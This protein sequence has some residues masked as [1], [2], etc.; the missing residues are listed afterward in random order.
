MTQFFAA[1]REPAWRTMGVITLIGGF[2]AGSGNHEGNAPSYAAT[3]AD[4]RA[5][6]RQFLGSGDTPVH[7]MRAVSNATFKLANSDPKRFALFFHAFLRAVRR[8]EN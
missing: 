4:G 7:E 5:A 8:V 2:L 1:F 6:I 3:I